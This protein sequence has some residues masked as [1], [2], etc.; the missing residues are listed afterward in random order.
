VAIMPRQR[1]IRGA[2]PLGAATTASLDVSGQV[3]K[4]H[5]VPG[6]VPVFLALVLAA[7][8]AGAARAETAGGKRARG[9][10]PP[11]TGSC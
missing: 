7:G 6:A 1:L 10:S 8:V 5:D 11:T 4:K 9:S 2:P 3:E